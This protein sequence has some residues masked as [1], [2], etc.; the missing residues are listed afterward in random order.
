MHHAGTYPSA[1]DPSGCGPC[2]LAV[3]AEACADKSNPAANRGYFAGGP[4]P[5]FGH[6]AVLYT[7]PP[8]SAY[9][10]ATILIVFGGAPP[11]PPPPPPL[12]SPPPPQPPQTGCRTPR[13]P[14]RPPA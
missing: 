7:S 10:G 13:P 3:E 5:R 6:T 8:D 1:G 2:L 11:P 4:P 14:Q 12:L 9:L